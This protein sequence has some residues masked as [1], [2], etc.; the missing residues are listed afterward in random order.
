VRGSSGV[1]FF[2]LGGAPGA[3]R[4]LP[5]LL[6]LANA[7][8]RA[9]DDRRKRLLGSGF[10]TE[11]DLIGHFSVSC[12]ISDR[13]SFGQLSGYCFMAFGFGSSVWSV[14]RRLHLRSGPIV[15]PALI[16]PGVRAG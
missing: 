16:A 9:A 11:I 2:F 6:F 12:V 14:P 3:P 13:L 5:G 10:G 1:F 4:R 7:H 8:G 15:T